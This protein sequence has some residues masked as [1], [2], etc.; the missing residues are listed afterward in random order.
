MRKSF[1]ISFACHA[2]L[3]GVALF[4]LGAPPPFQVKP[5]EPIEV[6]ISAVIS[7]KTQKTATTKDV[8]PPT[9]DPAPKQTTVHQRRAASPEGR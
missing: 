4:G 7:D 5:P 3:I 9:P 8:T 6:D 2:A 1:A